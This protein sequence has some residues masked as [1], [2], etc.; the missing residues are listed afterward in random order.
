MAFAV[1]LGK[2]VFLPQCK[3]PAF[4]KSIMRI[5]PPEVAVVPIFD[6]GTGAM[7]PVPRVGE[8]VAKN[9]IL[10]KSKNGAAWV[11]SPVSGKLR[12]IERVEHPVVGSVLCAFINIK[13]S[14]PALEVRGHNP[15]S[16]TSA[17]IIQAARMAC[18]FDESDGLPLFYKLQKA[19]RDRVMMTVADGID[20]SPYVSSSLKI[21]SEYGVDCADGL[22]FILKALDGGKAVLAAYDPG[23]LDMDKVLNTFGFVDVIRVSGGYPAWPRFAEQHCHEKYLRVGVQALRALSLAVRTGEPQTET[24]ITVSGDCI[25]NPCNVVVPTGTTVRHIL[26]QV[27]LKK[28]LK[29]VILG[30]TMRGVLC[31]NLDVPVFPGI[32]AITAVSQVERSVEKKCISCGRCVDICPHNL[33]PS[34]AVRMYENGESANPAMYGGDR[35]DACGACTAV[36]PSGID[37]TEIMLGEKGFGY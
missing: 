36:C 4:S 33:F 22:G 20:D 1:N 23:D 29:Y 34:E 37:V 3:E 30:D 25:E 24:V 26:E 10:A 6:F 8:N 9:A 35:C 21:I 13:D 12:R 32:R 7:L 5:K 28:P 16:M 19:K 31:P 17:G 11:V 18:I 27:V 15:S 2:G 14:I